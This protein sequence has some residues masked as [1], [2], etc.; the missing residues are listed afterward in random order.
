MD[1]T[2]TDFCLYNIGHTLYK[3]GIKMWSFSQTHLR[4]W[5]FRISL[6]E[7]EGD[8]IMGRHPAVYAREFLF[9]LYLFIFFLRAVLPDLQIC[10]PTRDWTQALAV[11]ALSPGW[12]TREVPCFS[13]SEAIM[14]TRFTARVTHWHAH[15]Q[16]SLNEWGRLWR[17]RGNRGW[18]GLGQMEELMFCLQWI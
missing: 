1:A 4:L 5:W 18:W 13:F 14:H 8:W 11:K 7:E 3:G 12:T 6:R 9:C 2:P 16:V 15:E 17:Q 10:S